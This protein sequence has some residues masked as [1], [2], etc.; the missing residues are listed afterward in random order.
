MEK[1][2]QGNDIR[3]HW[4]IFVRTGDENSA[5]YILT[6][7]VLSLYM[8][9]GKI[10]QRISA[11]TVE[12]NQV[13]WLFRGCDQKYKG[14]YSLTLIENEGEESM[15]TVDLC[16]AFALVGNSCEAGRSH[17]HPDFSIELIEL[18]SGL[19]LGTDLHLYDS[20]IEYADVSLENDLGGLSAGTPLRALEGRSISSIL[21]DLLFPTKEPSFV[22]ASVKFGAIDASVRYL[23]SKDSNSD[24]TVAVGT[25][26]TVLLRCLE[27]SVLDRGYWKEYNDG[28]PYAGEFEGLAKPSISFTREC[29]NIRDTY[30]IEEAK[31][32][33]IVLVPGDEVILSAGDFYSEG[34]TPH[35]NKGIPLPHRAAKKGY[36]EG[37]IGFNTEYPWYAS[38]S[39]DE[40]VVKQAMLA[41]SI[42]HSRWIT[43]RFTLQPSGVFPQ[44]IKL[45][46]R[47]TQL[48][49]Y[50]PHA[51]GIPVI[52]FCD[53]GME[54]TPWDRD[55]EESTETVTF[56]GVEMTYYV[57]TYKGA[58]RGETILQVLY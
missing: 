51:M 54:A 15:H 52:D 25:S 53:Q 14:A 12:G 34:P 39:P 18:S 55:F 40:P 22:G 21:D 10:R 6:D 23:P 16:D 17:I 41:N 38:T 13:Q 28:L 49:E 24:Y 32:K 44:V 8:S 58:D 42:R 3:I 45:P 43:P 7:K 35:N 29:A 27:E 36:V 48:Y 9:V 50:N 37:H 31:E 33:G 56:S 46:R 20:S 5:P 26:L 4:S 57:Y 2:R 11:F 1:I 19:Y 47:M 30:S